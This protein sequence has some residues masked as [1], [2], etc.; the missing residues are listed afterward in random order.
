[1]RLVGLG[2]CAAALVAEAVA[3]PAQADTGAADL[4]AP[5]PRGVGWAL[6]DTGP[7]ARPAWNAA[8]DRRLPRR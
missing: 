2:M 8:A 5:G 4:L 6:K 3:A 7:A 1:M